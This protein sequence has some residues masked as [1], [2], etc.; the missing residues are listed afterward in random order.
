MSSSSDPHITFLRPA[1][2]SDGE[3]KAME[4]FASVLCERVADGR[5][6]HCRVT[7]DMELR[8]LNLQ[9]RGKDSASDILSFPGEGEYLGDLAISRQRAAAQAREFGHSLAKEIQILMLHGVLHLLGFDH[10]RDRGKMS[11]LEREWRLKL[12]LPCGLI[13]R[14]GT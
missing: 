6:F 14:V 8:R 5:E 7:G 4:R 12:D 3:K 9:F 1:A 2:F 13:E 11:R 10:E